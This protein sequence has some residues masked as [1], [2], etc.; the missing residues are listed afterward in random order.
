M[1]AGQSQNALLHSQRDEMC[2]NLQNDGPVYVS[3]V[4]REWSLKPNVPDIALAQRDNWFLV[5]LTDLG[6][7]TMLDVTYSAL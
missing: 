3:R 7:S 4:N 2:K 5:K 1:K 6:G